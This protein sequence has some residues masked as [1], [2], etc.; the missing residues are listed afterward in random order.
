MC[1]TK[2]PFQPLTVHQNLTASAA[3]KVP[4]SVFQVNSSLH[5]LQGPSYSRGPFTLA[6]IF[7]LYSVDAASICRVKMKG[8]S[9]L[10]IFNSWTV[11]GEGR[12]TN[13]RGEKNCLS[14]WPAK[15]YPWLLDFVSYLFISVVFPVLDLVSLCYEA[16]IHFVFYPP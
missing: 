5:S 8:G 13:E 2:E 11:W 1:Y 9:S 6:R 14:I 4:F 16:V 7:P 3:W 12:S 15:K 10:L